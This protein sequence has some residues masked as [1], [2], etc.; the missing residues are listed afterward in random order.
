M[1]SKLIG[2]LLSLSLSAVLAVSTFSVPAFAAEEEILLNEEENVSG[3]FEENAA[4]F[5]DDEDNTF[6]EEE[7]EVEEA[8]TEDEESSL[9]EEI[10]EETTDE[11]DSATEADKAFEAWF[12]EINGKDISGDDASE[13]DISGDDVSGDDVSGDDAPEDISGNDE[14]DRDIDIKYAFEID[15]KAAT[16][17]QLAMIINPNKASY[18]ITEGYS[19]EWVGFYAPELPTGMEFVGW[20]KN[21]VL[22]NITSTGYY[23]E[24]DEYHSVKTWYDVVSSEDDGVTLVGKIASTVP[25]TLDYNMGEEGYSDVKYVQKG[26]KLSVDDPES[27]GYHFA[28]WFTERTGGSKVD[29]NTVAITEAVTYYAHWDEVTYKVTFH[30][31]VDSKKDVAVEKTYTISNNVNDNIGFE[32]IYSDASKYEAILADKDLFEGWTS[33]KEFYTGNYPV[34]SFM[35]IE[36]ADS[37]SVSVDM[38]AQWARDSY[39]VIFDAV[40]EEATFNFN[41]EYFYDSDFEVNTNSDLKQTKTFYVGEGVILTGR[42]FVR[43]GYKLAGWKNSANNKTIAASGKFDDLAAKDQTIT[44]TAIWQAQ[45]YT[46][47]YD[48]NGGTA[49]DKNK[50]PAKVTYNKSNTPYEEYLYNC[51]EVE[52]EEEDG[53]V[54]YTQ[55]VDKE[56]PVITKTGYEFRYWRNTDTG[57]TAWA[58]GGYSGYKDLKLTAEWE[59]VWYGIYLDFN[60]GIMST[61][62]T[63]TRQTRGYG[64]EYSMEIFSSKLS[65]A[66]YT[67][68]GWKYDSNDNGKIDDGDKTIGVNGKFKNLADSADKTVII[69][70]QWKA[71]SYSITYS[72]GKGAKQSGAVKKYT[73]DSAVSIAAPTRKGYKFTG[74]TLASKDK[75]ANGAQLVP[76]DENDVTKG[77]TLAA[78]SYGNIVLTANWLKE[79]PKFAAYK[80]QIL[81]GAAGVKT[82]AGEA[83]N[84][85]DGIFYNNGA[86]VAYA[87]IETVL[88]TTDLVRDGFAFKGYSYKKNGKVIENATVGGHDAKNGVVTLYAVWTAETNANVLSANAYVVDYTSKLNV[89]DALSK[90]SDTKKTLVYGKALS[91]PKLS[92]TGYKFLGWKVVSGTEDGLSKNKSGYVTKIGKNYKD[93][94]L[95]LAP[96]FEAKEIK[97]TFDPQGGTYAA[98]GKNKKEVIKVPYGKDINYLSKDF[99]KVTK[100]GYTLNG[101]Y[102]DTK[103]TDYFAFANGNSITS[104]IKATKAMTIYAVWKEIKPVKLQKVS[105]YL[106][107]DGT[108]FTSIKEDR[109][110]MYC[111]VQIA[112]DSKFTKSVQT[113]DMGY[114]S[115]ESTFS[116][117]V[118]GNQ[119]YARFRSYGIDSTGTKIYSDWSDTVMAIKDAPSAE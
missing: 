86:E 100:K 103:G 117:N 93:K 75:K 37:V 92:V 61:G 64:S 113:Y 52:N 66:G 80:L 90:L 42:E 36:G 81:P 18:H 88:G 47:T 29:L 19:R 22:L 69:Q 12:A 30:S 44:L 25:V 16:E 59:P 79:A 26:N 102:F 104:A 14:E 105:A 51:T 46:I 101:L 91:L 73:A 107:S 48:F 8:D 89:A 96:V 35:A 38:Y 43:G 45:D 108:L 17:E 1:K 15:G 111:E 94:T 95:V 27:V 7:L 49:I 87:D 55:G 24:D 2:R 84:E 99:A 60:G 10:I 58:Y 13:E 32:T 28:G 41:E 109:V 97:I 40:G 70:A 20:Y 4:D 98:T 115:G 83:V 67:L 112:T 34:V 77:Y 74:Y 5:M 62:L 53:S 6:F 65:K 78:G 31:N 68:T 114:V 56:N 54:S 9:D 33:G 72:N 3:E 11:A 118:Y 21:G 76:V 63:N 116:K 85:K 106:H 110:S 119:Y 23:D 50:Y 57:Y 39:N 82:A 71:N